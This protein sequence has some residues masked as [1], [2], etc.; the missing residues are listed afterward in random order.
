MPLGKVYLL[1]LLIPK[2]IQT[3]KYKKMRLFYILIPAIKCFR[4]TEFIDMTAG[5][6]QN[7]QNYENYVDEIISNFE[8]ETLLADDNYLGLKFGKTDLDSYGDSIMS[9][10]ENFLPELK[11]ST[12]DKIIENALA[13]NPS[14][15]TVKGVLYKMIFI[16]FPT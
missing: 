6:I 16:L 14:V 1:Q 5:G 8:S 2:P 12:I 13:Q 4:I 10:R 11:D 7:D 15:D 9:I 3:E